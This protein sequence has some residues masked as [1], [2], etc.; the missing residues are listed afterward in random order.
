MIDCVRVGILGAESCGKST[1]SQ[2]LAR[3]MGGTC[4]AEYARD[5]V[6]ALSRPYTYEDVVAIAQKQCEQLTAPYDT[7]WVFYDTELIITKVWFLHKYG[8]CPQFVLDMLEHYPL[9]CALLCDCDLPFEADPL[10]E[11][12]DIRPE[13]TAWYKRELERYGVPYL[14]VRGVGSDR[15]ICWVD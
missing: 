3:R 6:G 2:V 13:L 4:V 15:A 1:L 11:N 12:P 9:Q 10:R 8:Q 5:Y 7:R 14:M